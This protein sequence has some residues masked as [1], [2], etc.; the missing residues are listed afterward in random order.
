MTKILFFVLL[1]A[2]IGCGSAGLANRAAIASYAK[3]AD[4]L[5]RNAGFSEARVDA[6]SHLY[7]VKCTKCHELYNPADYD[8]AD[9]EYWMGRMSKKAR[10]NPEQLQLL[11]TFTA[12][13]RHLAKP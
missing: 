9:W 1:A 12:T 11:S 3:R 5:W 8:E 6:A 13:I 10:L 4:P 7:L 2:A